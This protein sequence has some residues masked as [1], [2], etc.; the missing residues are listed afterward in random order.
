TAYIAP[1]QLIANAVD[2]SL[3]DTGLLSIRSRGQFNRTLPPMDDDV[4]QFWEVLNYLLAIITIAALYLIS[5]V[6][7]KRTER[8]QLELIAS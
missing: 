8:K 2:V 1:F 3:D 7:R 5:R 4:R 6:W